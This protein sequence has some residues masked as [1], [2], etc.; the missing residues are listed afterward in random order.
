M[1]R[2]RAA[3]AG[4]VMALTLPL[5][6]RADDVAQMPVVWLALDQKAP[7]PSTMLEPP[8][9][10]L[11]IAGARVALAENQTTGRFTGQNWTLEEHVA[12]DD[13]GVMAAAHAVLAAG[14]R[15]IVTDLPAPLL[16]KVAD[17]PDAKDALL[18]DA[19]TSDDSLRAAD[20]R[21]NVLHL[22]PSRAMLADALMQYLI[23]KGWT[24]IMLAVGPQPADKLMAEAYRNSAKKFR[25]EI[26]ED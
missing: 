15:L 20:C 16:L 19:E 11:G 1:A 10:D 3:L 13:A 6:A 25:I 21:R 17:L 2:T 9:T 8:P 26:V 22:M 24:H 5:A 14:R 18:L 12:K 7:Q 23:V 4:L